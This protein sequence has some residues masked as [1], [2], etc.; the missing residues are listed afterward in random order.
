MATENQNTSTL[1]VF[2]N[3]VLIFIFYIYLTN[4]YIVKKYLYQTH[5][6]YSVFAIYQPIISTRT[7][8][9]SPC[10]ETFILFCFHITCELFEIYYFEL[11]TI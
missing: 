4:Y 8:T 5:C 9:C 10:E 11:E 7:Q 3:H 6:N 2:T 1:T